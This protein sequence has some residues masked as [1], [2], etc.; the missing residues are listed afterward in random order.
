MGV[1][2]G[3]D[4]AAVG[5]GVRVGGAGA[6]AIWAGLLGVGCMAG[7]AR[8]RAG[9]GCAWDWDG[10]EAAGRVT[11]CAEREVVTGSASLGSA[12]VTSGSTRTG[13]SVGFISAVCRATLARAGTGSPAGCP[14][15]ATTERQSRV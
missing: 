7:C 13:A 5:A 15:W 6:G 12:P 9:V 8:E 11:V 2:D 14:A 3:A 10:A 1:E 4:G